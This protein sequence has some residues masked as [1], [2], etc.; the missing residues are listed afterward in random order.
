MNSYRLYR[1]ASGQVVVR[2]ENGAGDGIMAQSE[3]KRVTNTRDYDLKMREIEDS[4]D[5]ASS[6]KAEMIACLDYA[7]GELRTLVSAKWGAQ[8]ALR[9]PHS[10]S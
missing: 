9:R 4:I 5:I 2:C 6:E 10:A 8:A 3:H 1:T 7:R